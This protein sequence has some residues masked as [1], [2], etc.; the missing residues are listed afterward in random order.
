MERGGDADSDDPDPFIAEGLSSDDSS[1]AGSDG[2]AASGPALRGRD[3]DGKRF[4]EA[5]KMR[6]FRAQERRRERERAK[7]AEE[8]EFR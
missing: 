2:V 5:L 3:N 1:D 8:R 7:R 4:R 6:L